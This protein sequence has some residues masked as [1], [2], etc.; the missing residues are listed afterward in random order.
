M[1]DIDPRDIASKDRYCAPTV[2]TAKI[3]AITNEN[4]DTLK[5][6]PRQR[7]NITDPTQLTT[8]NRIVSLLDFNF[9]SENL[10]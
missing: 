1:Y 8:L 2:T 10:L 3:T 6:V 4:N 9:V 5:A 7:K